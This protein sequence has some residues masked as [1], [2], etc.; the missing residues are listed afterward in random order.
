[1]HLAQDYANLSYKCRG[2]TARLATCCLLDEL[3]FVR[4][5]LNGNNNDAQLQGSNWCCLV[6]VTALTMV[7][8][9]CSLALFTFELCANRSITYTNCYK[10]RLT[11]NFTW[12]A[13]ASV[14]M[15]STA[16]L[17]SCQ[18]S[19]TVCRLVTSCA[20]CVLHNTS[21]TISA[22]SANFTENC[23]KACQTSMC[24]VKA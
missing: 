23:A 24:P 12:T 21:G 1:M 7:T 4:Q 8:N 17:R 19:C 15:V 6:P 22:I 3:I 20:E 14:M 11:S 16:C 5:T 9:A 2:Y 13:A 10:G 18:S